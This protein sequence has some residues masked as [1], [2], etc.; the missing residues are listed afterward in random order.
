[1]LAV[2]PLVVVTRGHEDPVAGIGGVNCG[3]DGAELSGDAPEGPHP[4]DAVFRLARRLA[5]ILLFSEPRR[6]A[7]WSLPP[8]S[9]LRAPL[10][11]DCDEE[12]KQA[13]AGELAYPVTAIR[14]EAR[15]RAHQQKLLCSKPSSSGAPTTRRCLEESGDTLPVLGQRDL[16]QVGVELR[17]TPAQPEAGI[18]WARS[19]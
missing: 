14:G 9:G 4:Q 1:M 11:E 13:E 17:D 16:E 6:A 19:E 8:V 10:G 7:R 5:A 3:L 15:G 12:G 2:P 18:G